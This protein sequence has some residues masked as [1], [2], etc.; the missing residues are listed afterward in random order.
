MICE[1]KR[2]F[3]LLE[4]F[5]VLII[6]SI[7]IT[8]LN[9]FFDIFEASKIKLFQSKIEN[10]RVATKNFENLY[11][12]LPGDTR[13]NIEP[14]IVTQV[15]NGDGFIGDSSILN[16][17]VFNFFPH[18]VKAKLIGSSADSE[19]NDNI[20]NLQ[21]MKNYFYSNENGI[22]FYILASNI[23]NNFN[24]INRIYML[25]TSKNTFFNAKVAKRI[26]CKF[27]D[28]N[29]ISG[30]IIS[31]NH[32]IYDKYDNYEKCIKNGAGKIKYNIDSKASNCVNSITYVLDL[33]DIN[34]IN[35][36]Y[37]GNYV[38]IFE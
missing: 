27:D 7:F 4:M 12:D 37:N 32:S 36:I 30:K 24:K 35:G 28:C 2:A 22:Y 9:Y 3:S 19:K 18:L 33:K 17:E 23:N 1:N 29:P 13:Q 25:S 15:G 34:K 11:G 10:I 6:A 38:N 8:S 20:F 26:D 14:N 16:K 31:Y 5:I 21:D